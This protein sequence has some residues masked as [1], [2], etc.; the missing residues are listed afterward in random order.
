LR[1]YLKNEIN[2]LINVIVEIYKPKRII[3]E[4]LDFRSP[5]LSKR[6]KKKKTRRKKLVKKNKKEQKR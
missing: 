6:M 2:R 4:K 1:D 5:E 3:V